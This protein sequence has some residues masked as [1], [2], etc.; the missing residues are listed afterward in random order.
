[1]A[2]RTANTNSLVLTAH[3]LDTHK[4]RLEGLEKAA[5]LLAPLRATLFAVSSCVG[6]VWGPVT[7]AALE[8]LLPM[9]P[10]GGRTPPRAKGTRDANLVAAPGGPTPPLLLLPPHLSSWLVAAP[11]PRFAEAARQQR[12]AHARR[13]RRTRAAAASAAAAAATAAE[14]GNSRNSRNSGERSSNVGTRGESSSVAASR[15]AQV[16]E[17]VLD[18]AGG[19]SVAV[20]GDE[21]EATP[22][23]VVGF[24]GR[25]VAVRET[26]QAQFYPSPPLEVPESV[27]PEE[28]VAAASGGDGADGEGGTATSKAAET[29]LQSTPHGE[30]DAAEA[31]DSKENEAAEA[32]AEAEARATLHLAGR[33]AQLELLANRHHHQLA[34]EL[35]PLKAEVQRLRQTSAQLQGRA[36]KLE[37]EN[38]QLKEWVNN[39]PALYETQVRL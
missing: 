30:V 37:R 16:R 10:R 13:Q 2:A 24:G 33:V 22:C 36:A 14:D 18:A 28:G 29:V 39:Y 11:D 19:T 20:A 23:V 25:K 32:E 27:I 21:G 12:K 9:R 7:A 31:D 8:A 4:A 3:I 34:A 6:D 15:W 1:M 35:P 26:L 5:T 38:S 17:V